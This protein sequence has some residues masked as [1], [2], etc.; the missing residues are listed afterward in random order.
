[1]KLR[2]RVVVLSLTCIL[3]AAQNYASGAISV[4]DSQL[5]R[6]Q[7]KYTV[8][9]PDTFKLLDVVEGDLNKDGVKDVVLMVKSTDARQWVTD[10]YSGKIDRNRRGIII[11]IQKNGSDQKL[12]QNLSIF[13]S[14]NEDGGV[15]FAPVLS[16]K[17]EKNLLH[18]HYDHGRYGSRDYRF[19]LQN[20][21]FQ[22]IGYDELSAHWSF[23]YSKT[24]INFLTG[25]K[26]FQQN[27]NPDEENNPQFIESW[28][29]F[30]H[31]P[32]SLSQIKDIDRLKMP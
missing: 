26:V 15:Y 32:I 1:M 23:I 6:A 17:I 4:K 20:H 18:V 28:K 7:S 16:L 5:E 14:E 27:N 19:R 22:M 21:D 24:S 30:Q 10:G 31:V 25:Q 9:I 2:S 11:L 12:I 13:S 8:F 3:S 29:K